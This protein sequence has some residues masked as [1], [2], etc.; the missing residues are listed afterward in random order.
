M[1]EQQAEEKFKRH[2]D[3]LAKTAGEVLYELRVLRRYVPLPKEVVCEFAVDYDE[4]DFLEVL[5]HSQG[6]Y[7]LSHMKS[8]LPAL[9]NLKSW[10]DIK[11]NNITKEI[12]DRLSL[13]IERREFE[14]RCEVCKDRG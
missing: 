4:R 11:V 13:R 8:E 3:D 7:L 12:L 6:E 5:D 9:Q 10:A 2:Q 1:M 14:G